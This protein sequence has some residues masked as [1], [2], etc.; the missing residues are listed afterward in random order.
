MNRFGSTQFWTWVVVVGAF[1][2]ASTTKSANFT[3]STSVELE[4][5]LNTARANGQNDVITLL[6][7][8]YP[9]I[10]PSEGFKYY[11]TN[12]NFS[13]TMQC[14]DGSAVLD[15]QGGVRVFIIR[16]KGANAHITLSGIEIKNGYITDP[17]LGAGLNIW[18][19]NSN[20]T[21]TNVVVANNWASALFSAVNA[22][23]MFLKT[24]SSST[25]TFRN[26]TF[27]NN[28]AKG[29]GGG[30]YINA[31]YGTAINFINNTLVANRGS[32]LGGGAYVTVVNGSLTL[33]NNTFTKNWTGY[34]SGGGGLYVKTFDNSTPVTLR[35][36]IM[37]DNQADNG[38]GADMFFEDNGASIAISH[39]CY[40]NLAWQTG[41]G[42]I[43]RSNVVTNPLLTEDMH[44]RAG[45]PC[46][47]TGT[48]QA[49]MVAAT[50][51]WGRPRISNTCVDMGAN[52][53]VV[54]NTGMTFANGVATQ[55]DTV[56]GAVCQLQYVNDLMSTNWQNSGSVVTAATRRVS[57]TDTNAA[58]A[59]F[60]RLKWM[61]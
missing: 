42:V 40:S 61:W 19:Q 25:L 30:M 24:D 35:N 55:W 6:S 29:M 14:T 27:T 58:T 32:T 8:V 31:G 47:D 43:L 33:E 51:L 34:G 46:I 59:R 9:T 48:N 22:S 49:W 60:Y 5:A 13:L 45:S 52:E 39:C 18:V 1:L 37:W 23:G 16:T 11:G 4:T 21:L 41:T 2:S 50:D 54:R 15:G 12:E 3:V 44:L 53:T 10:S 17:D 26:S 36:N 7:G 57:I 38:I 28:Y 20:V 56:N